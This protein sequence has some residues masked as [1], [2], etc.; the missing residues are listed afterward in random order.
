MKNETEKT[1]AAGELAKV[2]KRLSASDLVPRILCVVIALLIWLYVGANDSTADYER[3][4]SDVPISIENGAILSGEQNLSVMGGFDRIASVTVSGRRSELLS[5]SISDISV[6]VDVGKIT[7]AGNYTLPLSVTT[8]SGCI[9][10]NYSPMTVEVYIDQIA[11]KTVPVKV[12]SLEYTLD[13]SLELGSPVFDTA[14]VSVSGPSAA[15]AEAAYASVDL[16]LGKLTSGVTARGAL[17]VCAENGQP[18]DNPYVTLAQSTVGVTVPV[19][20]HKT[21]ALTVGCKY[22]YLDDSNATVTVRPAAIAVRADPTLLDGTD[23]VEIATIDEKTVGGDE[24]KTVAITLPDGMENLSGESTATISITHKNTVKKTVAIADLASTLVIDNPN[25]LSYRL[26]TESLNL[27]LRAP[28]EI[29]SEITANDISLSAE[30]NFSGVTGA[31]QLPL[32]VLLADKYRDSVYEIGEYT[33][34]VMIEK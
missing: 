20:A 9:L 31:L 11:A 29:A 25:R 1:A 32:T 6:S 27:V 34:S 10:K 14:A 5:Y 13:S 30:L 23:T 21:L 4:F 17:V 26:L 8:P 7:E 19:Y 15:I 2:K 18:I 12:G 28:A 24:N 22:G 16:T 3:I 33:V